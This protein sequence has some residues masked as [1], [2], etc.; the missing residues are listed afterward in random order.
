[1]EPD[2]VAARHGTLELGRCAE[3][4]HLAVIDDRDALTQIVRFFHIVRRQHDGATVGVVVADNL[5][6]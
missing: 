5:P 6:E 2:Q 3:R 4:N 1:M